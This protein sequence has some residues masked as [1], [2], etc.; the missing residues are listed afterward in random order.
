MKLPAWRRLVLMRMARAAARRWRRKNSDPLRMSIEL[1]ETRLL[2]TVTPSLAGSTVTFTGDAAADTLYLKA[3]GLGQLEYSAD[4][5]Q[6]LTDL[7]SG[8]QLSIGST[9]KINVNLGDGGDRLILDPTLEQAVAAAT[10]ATLTFTGG[11]GN[12]TLTSLTRPSDPTNHWNLSGPDAGTLNNQISFSGVQNLQG[13][14]GADDF[15]LSSGMQGT[16][17]DMSLDGGGGND[18]LDFSH[19][20]AGI[21]VDLTAGTASDLTEVEGIS[22]VTGGAGNDAIT[23]DGSDGVITPGSGNDTLTSG[24]GSTTYAFSANAAMG[25]DTITAVAGATSND[26]LDFSGTTSAIH[27][28]LSRTDAQAVNANLTLTLANGNFVKNV[29]GTPGNDTITGNAA[30]NIIQGGA[31]DD[32]LTGGGGNDT[33]VYDAD[34]AQGSDTIV[35][36][37]ADTNDSGTLDFSRTEKTGISVDLTKSATQIVAPNVSLSFDPLAINNVTGG[38]GDDTITAN[39]QNDI[40]IGGEGKNTFVLDGDTLSGVIGIGGP[41]DADGVDTLDFSS[42]QSAG[43][44]LDLSS[45]A[46]QQITQNLS[47]ILDTASIVQRVIEGGG[48]DSLTGNSRNDTFVAGSGNDTW[49]SGGGNNTYVLNANAHMGAD[50]INGSALGGIDTLDFSGTTAAV[51]VDLSST[52]A[53]TINSNLKLTLSPGNTVE[54]V[55]GGAGANLLTGNAQNNIITAGPGANTLAGGGGADTNAFN[56][57]IDKGATTI[58]AGPNGPSGTL[59]FSSTKQTAITVSL[60][61]TTQNVTAQMS[62]TLT[63]GCGVEN[64]IGGAGTNTLTGDANPNLFT[65][66]PNNNT[67]SGG[68]GGDTFRINADLDQGADVINEPTGSTN[69]TLDFSS[70]V[71][72]GITIDLS[73]AASQNLVAGLSLTLSSGDIISHYLGGAGNDTV[74]A[75]ANNDILTSGGGA[76]TFR[77][78]A[79]IAL[80]NDQINLAANAGTSFDPALSASTAGITV[81]ATGHHW[82]VGDEVILSDNG[83]TGGDIGGLTVGTPYFL[84]SVSADGTTIQHAHNAGGAAIALTPP[85]TPGFTDTLVG[86]QTLDFSP[87]Q[88]TGV[89]VNLGSAILQQVTHNTSGPNLSMLFS[90]N[91]LI[92]HLIEGDGNDAI[93]ANSLDDVITVG[94]GNDTI[95]S[96]A[97]N[98]TIKFDADHQLG[99][100]QINAPTRAG[101]TTTLDFS[102]TQNAGISIDL[103]KTTAQSVVSAIL[104][105]T[106]A[107]NNN[108]EAVIGGGGSDTI[109]GNSLANSLSGGAGNDTLIGNGGADTYFYQ[110]GWGNDFIK[111]SGLGAADPD[112]RISVNGNATLQK[113]AGTPGSMELAVGNDGISF[114]NPASSLTVYATGLSV[115]S[116]DPALV[117]NLNLEGGNISVDGAL[118]LGSASLTMTG[119]NITLNQ[120]I[121]TTGDV[122]L[123]ANESDF[124][125]G[126]FDGAG[127]S[128]QN[129][130]INVL[131]ATINARNVTLKAYATNDPGAANATPTSG[132]VDLLASIRPQLGLAKTDVTTS[133]NLGAGTKIFAAGTVNISRKAKTSQS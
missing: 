40:L 53:Q 121:T 102:A 98:D 7:G 63:Q 87:T 70:T 22:N 60:T 81:P 64:V 14:L 54:N 16:H 72:K 103:S 71:Q 84:T 89:T 24:S 26:T 18:T 67:L 115:V 44:T 38:D 27:I 31:G 48:A 34:S 23:S 82:A 30:D 41:G 50:T 97:G 66:G 9:S 95:T 45:Q 85:T 4:N 15:V 118:N 108:V 58:A 62:L 78:N 80:G 69:N 55:I 79:D 86:A 91:N 111:D 124:S 25:S 56:A 76:V 101:G 126:L 8:A 65:A 6:Y 1:L 35:E 93:T 132:I 74:T 104:T 114:Q 42:T 59:D 94:R 36:H 105:L 120:N 29:I 117:A 131:G 51:T 99:S 127:G 68:G 129:A 49:T 33:F 11:P 88:N 57:D 37:A 73:K 113:L 112:P 61:S 100:D 96:G 3:N 75:N 77:I 116:I 122:T 128:P 10:G 52:A 125:P 92:N 32:S 21:V 19:Y 90:N 43:V 13:S 47:L 5:I 130:S 133:V 12:N 107:A 119:G 46:A 83:V 20:S 106:L 110:S 39:S 2:L 17:S 109:A 28:D 123:D